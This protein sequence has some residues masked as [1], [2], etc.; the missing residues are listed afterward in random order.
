MTEK[1]DRGMKVR[2]EV[3]GNAHVDRSEA[4]KT[5]FDADFQQ[6]IIETAWGS[7]WARPGLKREIR[8]LVTLSIL[9]ATGQT[10]EFELHLKATQNTDVTQD[11]VK[12]ALLHV[13]GYAGIPA[14][15]TAFAIAKKVFAELDEQAGK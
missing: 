13:A 15:N 6:F 7:I 4:N 1:Y 8:Q 5:E 2:R 12:E 9:A 10:H 14:A 11:E 3:L